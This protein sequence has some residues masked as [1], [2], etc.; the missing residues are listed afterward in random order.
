MCVFRRFSDAEMRRHSQLDK[1]RLL[2][3]V[4]YPVVPCII[5]SRMCFF[6]SVFCHYMSA[7]PNRV[8]Y[9][10]SPLFIYVFSCRFYCSLNFWQVK[11]AHYPVAQNDS[12]KSSANNNDTYPV[13]ITIFAHK[14]RLG[15]VLPQQNRG[16]RT[17]SASGKWSR[18]MSSHYQC[19]AM[20]PCFAHE[21]SL[22]TIGALKISVQEIL[23]S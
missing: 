19:S 14:T 7:Q 13:T 6:F 4:S 21:T 11:K 17:R 12:T 22:E 1:P 9:I 10:S 18:F 15:F 23:Y 3:F 8:V 2:A 16:T 5:S 20:Y